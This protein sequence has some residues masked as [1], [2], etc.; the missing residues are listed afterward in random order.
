MAELKLDNIYKVYDNK[1][2]AVEDFNLHIQDK[3]FIVFVGPSGC[4]KSTTLR[5][6]AGLEEISKG[7][8]YIDEKR[9]NDVPPKDR[10]I[11]MVFQNYALYPHMS[12]YDNMAF[13]LKL[14]K[15][16]KDEIDRRVK[17]AAKILG[18]EPYLDRKPKAL[19]G[20]QRQRVALG[21][22]IVRDAKVFLMDEPLSNLDA[23]LRVQM[24]AEIAKLH[25]RLQTTTIYV[26]HDQ[27]EA[28]TMATRLVVMKDGVI[29]QV[30]APKEV[31]EKP[32]NVF[33]GGFIGSPAMNFFNGRLEDGKFVIGKTQIAVPEGKMKVLRDQGYTGKDIVLGIRPEDI[34][35]EPVFIDASAGSKI[36]AR[37]DVSELTGAETMIYSSI[38]GQDFVARVDSRTD[39]KPGQNLELAFDMNKAHFFD[40]NSERRIRSEK[41]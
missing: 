24:R 8:F 27:T 38:E 29:Q 41:E 2:T 36:N 28:M 18:L 21:R 9:V 26:T 11:A 20:G 23:K 37:I 30:G 13:G 32:E 40:A 7:D 4:G 1:V 31:Y 3:E 33:V 34:H 12:V 35:D 10:D 15:F 6:I 16:P 22:A 19:S 17:E 39:I 5:M 14:R 25:Q